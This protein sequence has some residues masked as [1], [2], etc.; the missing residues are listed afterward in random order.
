MERLQ[1]TAD[2]A[3]AFLTGLIDKMGLEC[4]VTVTSSEDNRVRVRITGKDNSAVIGYRGETLDAIQYLTLLSANKGEDNFVN[5]VLDTENY[6]EK[7]TKVL[8]DLANR[9]ADKAYRT[10]RRVE[11][12]PMNPFE[13][14]IIHSAL[15][16][17]TK[18]TTESEGEG[19]NRHVVIIP[20]N[21]NNEDVYD[22]YAPA[23]GYEKKPITSS[24]FKR[25]GFGKMKR[26]GYKRG[27]R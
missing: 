25:N 4:T 18:A 14:R 6:R 26:F 7:R 8:T 10:G 21:V 17:S 5:V 16:G 9:L 11:L 12:E 27:E 24:D 2:N 3:V 15:Q 20:L 1:Q 13:R 19:D 22:P 23:D